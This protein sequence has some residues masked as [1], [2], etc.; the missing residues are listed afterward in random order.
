MHV[1]V[2]FSPIEFCMIEMV[3]V[4]FFSLNVHRVTQN[5][6]TFAQHPIST[7]TKA[8]NIKSWIWVK[9]DKR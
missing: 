8:L 5:L 3:S 9:A 6:V 1:E 4:I 2:L 7:D